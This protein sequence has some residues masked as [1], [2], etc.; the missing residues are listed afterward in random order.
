MEARD[1]C[2]TDHLVG[3]DDQVEAV[4]DLLD[5]DF[6]RARCLGI[7]GPSGVGKTTF[8][9]ALFDKLISSFDRYCFLRDVSASSRRDGLVF[10][11]KKVLSNILGE[12][13]PMVDISD[14]DDG[15][16]VI[17]EKVHDKKV[18]IVLDDV[19]HRKQLEKLIGKITWFGAG[20]RV[21]ITTRSK[22]ILEYVEKII[23]YELKE[24]NSDQALQLY[25]NHA[26]KRESPRDN[27]YG[28]LS[29]DIVSTLG[30]L[31]LV[32]E[33]IGSFLHGKH[34][35]I[36][37]DTLEQLRGIAYEDVHQKL[38]ISYDTL[39]FIQKQNFLDIACFPFHE[40]EI[41]ASYMWKDHD[42]FPQIDIEVLS[43]LSLIKIRENG[44]LWMHDLLKDLGRQIVHDENLDSG[45]RS[46]LWI[47]DE[48]M[49]MAKTKEN[50]RDIQALNL[51]GD[52]TLLILTD[53]DFSRL[54]NL[55]FLELDGG[56]FIGDFTNLFSK[57]RW[58]SWSHCPPDLVATNLFSQ[59]LVVLQLSE[60]NDANDWE[61][62]SQIKMLHNLKV[63]QL[64][65]LNMIKIDLS[66]C[67]ALERLI[68]KECQ[69]LVDIDRSIGDL[70]QLAYLNI[71]GCHRLKDLSGEIGQLVKLEHLSLSNCSELLGLPSSIGNLKS[72]IKLDL[73]FTSIEGLPRSIGYLA[74]L[75]SLSLAG[76][77]KIWELPDS[78]GNLESL[79]EL[80][81]SSTCI[82]VLPH[83]IGSIKTLT[84]IKMEHCRL[85]EF[86]SAIG[87]SMKLEVIHARGCST[88]VGEVSSEIGKLSFLKI[89][90]LSYTRI[91]RVPE[92]IAALPRL[93][94]LI[95]ENCDEL[96]VLPSLPTSLTR[97]LVSSL[98]LQ[99]ISDLS[100]L[101]NLVNLLL[102]NGKEYP[103]RLFS[104][105]FVIYNFEW[106]RKLSKLR[107]LKL[108]VQ[109]FIMSLTTL[110]SLS[111]LRKLHM[112][113]LLNPKV[114]SSVTACSGLS[115]LR[116]LIILKLCRFRDEEIH[117]SGLEK[118]RH[119]TVHQCPVL[120]RIIFPM[121]GLKKLK[122]LEIRDCPMLREIP[123]LEALRTLQNQFR[124]PINR[125]SDL[126]RSQELM[127]NRDQR[128]LMKTDSESSN[129][130]KMKRI[131]SAGEE[132]STLTTDN[133]VE[134]PPAVVMKR[135][136]SLSTLQSN[137]WSP[138]PAVMIRGPHLL[139]TL[140]LH[141]RFVEESTLRKDN[142]ESTLTK[143]DSESTPAS[144]NSES[145]LTTDNS[146]E[147]P[148]TEVSKP[149]SVWTPQF[150][151]WLTEAESTLTSDNSVLS[152]TTDNSLEHPSVELPKK[153]PRL[154]WTPQL[155]KR[156][157]DAVVLLGIGNAMPKM[158]LQL[159]KVDGLTLENVD[160]HL[161]K[162][163]LYLKTMQRLSRGVDELPCE[164]MEYRTNASDTMIPGECQ[165]VTHDCPKIGDTPQGGML[166]NASATVI[167]EECQVV[168]QNCPK[169]GDTL[170][171]G[172][173]YEDYRDKLPGRIKSYLDQ[174]TSDSTREV[175]TVEEKRPVASIEK[176]GGT[177][178][179]VNH[180]VSLMNIDDKD[181]Q[182]VV[183]I[184]GEDG[185][186][187]TT[188]AKL[189]YNRVSRDFDGCS[190]LEDIKETAR[191]SG[192]LQLLQ[193]KLISDI[194]KRELEDV[195]F[196]SGGIEF[197]KDL[198]CNMRVLIILDDV[199]NAFRVQKLIGDCFDCFASGSRIL[200][201]TRNS[202]VL[203]DSP[204]IRT[205]DVSQLDKD[206]ALQLFRQHPSKP[207]PSF[208]FWN[209]ELSTSL[210]AKARLPLFIDVMCAVCKN[211]TLK[212]CQNLLQRPTFQW[213]DF[214]I[215]LEG[216]LNYEQKQIFLDIACFTTGMDSRIALYLWHDFS[217]LPP[218]EIL[219]P[220]AKIGENNQIWMHSTLRRL[221]REI[222]RGESLTNPGKRSRLFNHEIALNT[223]KQKKGT[224]K[225]EALSLNFQWHTSVK[226]TP[227]DFESMPNIRF[228][229]MDHADITGDFANL[230]PNLRWLR[231]RGCPRHLQVT[232][233]RLGNLTILDLSWSKVTKDWEGWDQIE[234]K[235]L[236]VLDL[237][238]CA[239]LLVTPKFSGCKNLAILILERCSQLVKIDHSIDDLRCLVSLNLKFCAELSM[240][241]VEVGH[242]TALKE[243]YMDGTSIQ[244]IPI[245]IGHLKQLE[246]LTAS[247]CFSLTQLPRTICHLTNI[248]FL[249]LDG[250]RIAAL[251]DSIGELVT[252]KHLSLRDCRRI[253]KL[254]NSIGNIG[255]SLVELDMSGTGVSK[256]PDSILN[257][258]NLKVLRMDSCFFREFPPDIG[259]LASLEEIHASWCRSLEGGIPS[260]IG[261]LH[262]LRILRLRHSTISSLPA[263][264]H[265]LSNL[266]TLDLLHCDMI[267]KLPRLPSSIMV[268]CVDDELKS[269]HLP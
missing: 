175:A 13:E 233:F 7:H 55:R 31:P 47:S 191:V 158:I 9:T 72:L 155:H 259:E 208:L 112:S 125:F 224:E 144:D 226:L 141:K 159:M 22:S 97:L 5:Y 244:E 264:I 206:Q 114:R 223:I 137:K 220:L 204:Q 49:D 96:Q 143:D 152:L 263:E 34:K 57:L 74:N 17:G 260:E 245:S 79:T 81:L 115:N 176:Y 91:R 269:S 116:N 126:S 255:R 183:V 10:L 32:I 256:F 118:L 82:N 102:S 219:T 30:G 216:G 4:M 138:A 51:A 136:R 201:T 257:L 170:K 209:Y 110:G 150:R 166:A 172:M 94:E 242:L 56:S 19:D 130:R 98:S 83:S 40:E 68:I 119:L 104:G 146:A 237:T 77:K 181:K 135:P 113:G 8:A 2:A 15:M 169:I 235:N 58:F 199:E 149:P 64:T 238:G 267:K 66:G 160:S 131:D 161:R 252:L 147:D 134:D 151:K 228:L 46:R 179:Q 194:L 132:E 124:L 23:P 11:Q 122:E 59:N 37:N 241:P 84:V 38:K 213:R 45:K 153:R 253:R 195:A 188:L 190:F 109:H 107:N 251:P 48:A 203:E 174:H 186:G 167:P 240:L 227:E 41:N 14:V 211:T 248:S 234:M 16:K 6:G 106:I 162:Y 205:Y 221:G 88:M 128:V 53:E 28:R 70:K 61:G 60:F 265:Q 85:A 133:S 230:L 182:I 180:I 44:G 90:D 198:L 101:T 212:E 262:N 25:M 225:V 127:E 207:P 250:T 154:V 108:C 163:R 168:I 111:R 89:L 148:L 63:L 222:V 71:E 18:L 142:S 42:F 87:F 121:S 165:V 184:Q 43:S 215:I 123:G 239:D 178:Y 189:I 80:D 33:V 185:I 35:T 202:V 93:E 258:Q 36:W 99:S 266:R 196:V 193:I 69:E 145:T 3:I 210:Y 232:N 103:S 29:K 249:S 95:L 247:N 117:L 268:L 76:C 73:S 24:M 12:T 243:L 100:N 65:R 50:K 139:S 231:W 177:D 164:S 236:R 21:V 197:F 254:P 187:K 92:T 120:E 1:D 229:Q 140:Q 200:V 157:V 261:K 218:S 156:F 78:T 214:Q 27:H 105:S 39:K 129:S 62:W 217:L 173:F 246:T 20:S 54:P 67:F 75:K 86:P 171:G 26:F 192:G 52:S